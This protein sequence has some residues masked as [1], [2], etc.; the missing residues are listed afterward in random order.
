M[1]HRLA[2]RLSLEGRLRGERIDQLDGGIVR[3]LFRGGPDRGDL[4]SL[5]QRPGQWRE[6]RSGPGTA[7]VQARR[8]RNGSN[9]R[10]T[11]AGSA[12]DQQLPLAR[13]FL[14]DDQVP[15]APEI[16]N[17]HI[18]LGQEATLRQRQRGEIDEMDCG[19][20]DDQDEPVAGGAQ[21]QRIP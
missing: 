4:S 20:R 13:A 9:R 12:D 8:M 6:V 16:V 18:G 17:E 1:D 11:H 7:I 19:V 15:L 21:F 3:R 5:A 10:R 2:L 14:T